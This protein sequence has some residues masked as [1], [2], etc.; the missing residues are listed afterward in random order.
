MQNLPERADK[1]LLKWDS[2]ITVPQRDKNKIT[3]PLLKSG[4][5]SYFPLQQGRQFLTV[6]NG[7]NLSQQR[8]WF[9]GTDEEPFLVEM[10]PEV[11]LHFIKNGGSEDNF[12]RFLVPE[13]IINISKETGVSYKRQGDIFAIKFCGEQYFESRL[14]RL[15]GNKSKIYNGR[16]SVLGT[17]HEANGLAITIEEDHLR[18]KI[19]FKGNLEA[20]DHKP[21]V[22]DDAL[23]VLGQT[24]HIVYPQNAD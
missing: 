18:N 14:N 11:V 24:R 22:L 15:L 2:A 6:L 3:L 19:L 5:L 4:L 12:Y 20:P 16:F 9:G 10:H 23:Y 21:L 13:E 7:Q 17:R 1:A 8:A